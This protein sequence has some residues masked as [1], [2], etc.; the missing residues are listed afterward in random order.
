M[1]RASLSTGSPLSHSTRE[2]GI[3]GSLFEF[4]FK[5]H[6]FS[7]LTFIRSPLPPGVLLMCQPAFLGEL[8]TLEPVFF[9]FVIQRTGNSCRSPGRRYFRD[10]NRVLFLTTLDAQLIADID[11]PSGFGAV[12][13]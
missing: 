12:S 3:D 10:R 8:L 11:G 13:V 7:A 1:A 4:V 9:G 5:T 2:S 6:Y